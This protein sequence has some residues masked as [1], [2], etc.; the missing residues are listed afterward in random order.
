MGTT[1]EGLGDEQSAGEMYLRA[2]KSTT[3]IAIVPFK[4][5]PRLII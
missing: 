5:I 4:L 3:Q 2:I 1:L